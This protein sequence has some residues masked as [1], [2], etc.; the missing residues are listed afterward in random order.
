MDKNS[1]TILAVNPGSRYVGLAL[2]KDDDLRDWRV[3]SLGKGTLE[4][5]KD[6]FRKLLSSFVDRYGIKRLVLKK[7]GPARSSGMLDGLVQTARHYAKEEGI[8]IAEIP[9]E[10]IEGVLIKEG[11]RNKRMLMETV[12]TRYTFLLPSVESQK[13]SR[14]PYLIRMFEAVAV[15]LAYLA[16]NEDEWSEVRGHRR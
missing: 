8:G 13:Q 3:S 2:F 9:L 11:R 15:G 4:R 10:T 5:R 16:G 7:V 14:N 1:S 6:G 12:A